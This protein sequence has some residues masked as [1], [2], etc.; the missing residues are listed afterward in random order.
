M[1]A[2]RAKPSLHASP[3]SKATAGLLSRDLHLTVPL[4]RSGNRDTLPDGSPTITVYA[5]EITLAE[6]GGQNDPLAKPPLLFLQGGPGCESPRP[7]AD[8]GLG[9]LGAIL[10]HH[11]VIL[12]DQRGTGRS[13]P[14]DRPDAG[15]NAAGTARLLTHFRADEIVED[16]EDLRKAL[17][18]ERWSL[19][20]QSFGGFCVTRYLSTHADA[21]ETAY[22]TGGLPAVG[23]SIDQV[24]ELTW[25]RMAARSA[26]H[27]RRYPQ[28][29]DRLAALMERA[30]R[31]ELH[32]TNGDA[33]G[34]QRLRSLGSLLGASGGMDTLRHLLERDPHTWAFRTDLAACLAFNPRNPLYAV[35]HESCWADGGSTHWAAERTRPTVFDDDP[36]LLSG[37]HL[38]RACLEEDSALRPWLP[39]A[40]LLAEVEWPRLYDE[41]ALTGT[42][43]PGAAAVYINDVYVPFTTS[44]STAALIPGLRTWV[45][46]EYEHD[47]S[48]ASGGAV[49][50][51]LRELAGG[52][53][54]R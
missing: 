16:C 6:A 29:R 36:T 21:V 18:I 51:R 48:R 15:G 43:T 5:R 13:T 25:A 47:G 3:W 39:V 37:E 4:D 17:G 40:E 10:E 12:L 33:V 41:S 32:T 7:S 26:E 46:S 49:F 11:R 34:P 31:G 9:W 30:K 27:Y 35:I 23:A 45:T 19:L 14:V 20:G 54:A 53:V 42:T 50:K 44:M 1:S 52:T 28:D 8:A 38:S 2:T 22:L 24:Y